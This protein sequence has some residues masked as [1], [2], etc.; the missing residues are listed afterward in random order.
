MRNR[1]IV[2]TYTPFTYV[3]LG[4]ILVGKI[5][6]SKKQVCI[7]PTCFCCPFLDTLFFHQESALAAA[8]EDAQNETFTSKLSFAYNCHTIDKHIKQITSF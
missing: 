3:A 6:K 4:P 8:E 7:C 5:D 1:N 2:L